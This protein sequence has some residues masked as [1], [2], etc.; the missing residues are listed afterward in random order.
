MRFVGGGKKKRNQ[1]SVAIVFPALALSVF[2]RISLAN[3]EIRVTS[4]SRSCM[5]DEFDECDETHQLVASIRCI[6][7]SVYPYR[8]VCYTYVSCSCSMCIVYVTFAAR[9][10]HHIE[11]CNMQAIWAMPIKFST[12][13]NNVRITNDVHTLLV[14]LP[15]SVRFFLL[16]ENSAN[17]IL[18][19]SHSLY[20]LCPHS[21]VLYL[22]AVW[23]LPCASRTHTH[24]LH[25]HEW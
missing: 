23:R 12:E 19:C 18:Y 25:I 2:P 14:A 17:M 6:A 10:S 16:I 9:Y 3:N 11:R 7:Y 8:V 21:R 13:F 1:F 24:P 22:Y 20:V 4:A 5:F 15:A